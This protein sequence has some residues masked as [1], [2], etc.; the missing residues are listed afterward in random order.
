MHAKLSDSVT[1]W[2]VAHQAHL[3]MGFSRQEYWRGLPCRPLGDLLNPGINLKLLRFLHWQAVLYHQCHLGSPILQRNVDYYKC[4]SKCRITMGFPCS[5]A[6]KESAYNEGDLGS[7][8]GLGR[9]PGKGKGY[10]LQYTG[11]ENSMECMGVAKSWTR[12]SDFHFQTI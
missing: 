1:P 5:S 2:T 4:S 10:P 3:S 11:L 7:V 12:L 9:F 8:P 6:D